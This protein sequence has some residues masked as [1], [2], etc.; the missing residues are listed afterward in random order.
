M[1]FAYFYWDPPRE[2]FPFVLPLLNRPILW[3]GFFFAL[4]FFLGYLILRRELRR[5]WDSN[6]ARLLAD[7]ITLFVILGAVIGAR[8]GDLLF[9]QNLASYF[10]D[11][12]GVVKVW[13]GGLAS[14]G[15]A[16]GMLFALFILSLL[17]KQG[18]PQLR[19]LAL[20]DLVV[21]P[22]ALAAAFIRV[23]N[24]INQEILG[25]PTDLPWGVVFGHPL[26]GSRPEPRHPVQLYEAFFYLLIFALLMWGVPK[27]KKAG[28]TTGLF[29][30]LVFGFRFFIEFLKEEQSSL[31]LGTS[32][33]TM[34]QFLS[35]PFLLIGCYLFF[36]KDN[37]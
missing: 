10:H 13:E 6:K 20:L 17:P 2:M 15:G 34:G 12:L 7:R 30:I 18:L 23:G 31:L 5:T 32:W 9:Y 35:L 29:L 1:S 25:R 16:V 11:P 24:F 3:Y 28:K 4:G 36:R 8:L 22:T 33:F 37:K 14:H 19:W 21:V 26:D 27:W